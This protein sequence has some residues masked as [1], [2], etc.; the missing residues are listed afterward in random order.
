MPPIFCIWPLA[1]A[2]V[3]QGGDQRGRADTNCRPTPHFTRRQTL[4]LFLDDP[5]LFDSIVGVAGHGWFGGFFTHL[6]SPSRGVRR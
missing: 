5:G 6:V 1:A 2:G 3:E 4:P